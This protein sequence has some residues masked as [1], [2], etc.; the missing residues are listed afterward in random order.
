[1]S[2]NGTRARGAPRGDRPR[3]CIAKEVPTGR[4]RGPRSP[5][6]SCSSPIAV[7]RPVCVASYEAS[8]AQPSRSRETGVP[9][10]RVATGAAVTISTRPSYLGAR[11]RSPNKSNLAITLAYS[12]HWR[13]RQLPRAGTHIAVG[14]GNSRVFVSGRLQELA[15]LP[16]PRAVCSLVIR[17]PVREPPRSTLR[18]AVHLPP[19]IAPRHQRGFGPRAH[20]IGA[21]P[22][23]VQSRIQ[24][25]RTW[26]RSARH[27]AA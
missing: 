1:M 3:G 10:I 18:L 4:K 19:L 17:G 9:P 6:A 11:A 25:P 16:E 7:N 2:T 8:R 24:G 22:R 20:S 26:T 14:R 5:G 15:F 21:C 13:M 23:P 12:D 27:S